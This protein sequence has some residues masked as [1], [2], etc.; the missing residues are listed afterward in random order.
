M[1]DEQERQIV[2]PPQLSVVIENELL[3]SILKAVN[4]AGVSTSVLVDD[5]GTLRTWS[6]Q[7]FQDADGRE[8]IA[9]VDENRAQVVRVYNNYIQVDPVLLPAAEAAIWNPGAD[10]TQLYSVEYSIT[11]IDAGGAPVTYSIGVEVGGA[12]GALTAD[13]Y[14]QFNSV[15]PYPGSSGWRGPYIIAGDDDVR[16]VASAANDAKVDWRIRRIDT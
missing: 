7:V 15:L 16:G 14:W 4:R 5:D 12:G 8:R 2:F 10:A 6:L 1:A 11:N 13:E 3:E 9:L